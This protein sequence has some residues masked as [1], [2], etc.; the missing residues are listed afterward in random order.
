MYPLKLPI[1]AENVHTWNVKEAE[2]RNLH[3]FNAA[4]TGAPFSIADGLITVSRQSPRKSQT[5]KRHHLN[6]W[7]N[8]E[9]RPISWP[10]F[11]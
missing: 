4:W 1:A 10:Q 2:E 3:E 6:L 8:E 5:Q 7:E 11:V 9:T